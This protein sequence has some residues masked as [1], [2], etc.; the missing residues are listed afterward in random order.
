MIVTWKWKIVKNVKWKI[1]LSKLKNIIDNYNWKFTWIFTVKWNKGM[2]IEINI[3]INSET[4]LQKW[5]L[6][7]VKMNVMISM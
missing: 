2:K 7:Y 6:D 5:K 3:F 1:N 4:F